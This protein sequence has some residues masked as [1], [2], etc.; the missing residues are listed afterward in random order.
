M[1]TRHREKVLPWFLA[2]NCAYGAIL[3]A[4]TILDFAGA[5]RFWFGAL[6]FYLPH[7]I[8]ALPGVLLAILSLRVAWRWVWAPLL[9]IVWVLGPIMGFCWSMH[10][11]QGPAEFRIMTWNVKYGGPGKITQAAMA[12]EIDAARPDIVLMQDSTGLLDGPL[13]SFF[14]GWNVQS[15]GQY[16][17]ASKFPLDSGEV[18][19]IPY[20]GENHTCFRCR[21]HLGAKTIILYDAHFQSP[22]NGLNAFREVRRKPRYLPEAIDELEGNVEAR[23]SQAHALGRLIE[24][25]R[26]PVVVAGDL[27]SPDIS[28]ACANLRRAGLHDAFAESGKGYGYTYG[29]LLLRHK[30]PWLVP[31]WVRID[32]IMLS[33]QLTSRA[34]WTGTDA[35]SD[36]RP[37]IADIT[38]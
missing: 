23:L 20:F 18:R 8:W 28:L 15:S 22:R 14:K 13:G 24:Q 19:L 12:L 38:P 10:T 11:Q 16:I 36:H 21:L 5:D 17:I 6:N 26:E 35:L 9:C 33:A 25:E 31:S 1:T 34:C 2:L 37:V 30:L 29:H 27:N 7:V 3:A 32:H 4:L